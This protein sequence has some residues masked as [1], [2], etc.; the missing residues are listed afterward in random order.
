MVEAILLDLCAQPLLFNIQCTLLYN[1]QFLSSFR[2]KNIDFLMLQVPFGIQDVLH[3][4]HYA[5]Q[6]L[7]IS[8]IM[9]Y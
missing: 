1:K 5:S 9:L 4:V 7:P 6:S 2:N 3:M 8:L